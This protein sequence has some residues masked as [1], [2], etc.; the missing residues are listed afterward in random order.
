MPDLVLNPFSFECVREIV[1][2][3]F[4]VRKK[5]LFTQWVGNEVLKGSIFSIKF[6]FRVKRLRKI[7]KINDKIIGTKNPWFRT[8]F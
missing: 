8:Y 1:R 2:L 5:K 3:S 4:L 6:D 7:L